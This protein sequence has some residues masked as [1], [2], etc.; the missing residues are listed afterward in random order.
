MSGLPKRTTLRSV[1]DREAEAAAAAA[2][3]AA[4][5]QQAIYAQQQVPL[6][7]GRRF[8]LGNPLP[9]KT[10]GQSLARRNK[11]GKPIIPA[12]RQEKITG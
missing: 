4:A 2:A 10:T 11:N 8:T 6:E 9:R 5:E 3:A 7:A 12:K 1:A